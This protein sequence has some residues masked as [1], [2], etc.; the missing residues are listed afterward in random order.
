MNA[1]EQTLQLIKNAGE[2]GTTTNEIVAITG[3]TQNRVSAS[4]S[5]LF[6]KGA[7]RRESEG[8]AYRYRF[9]CELADIARRR[10]KAERRPPRGHVLVPDVLITVAVGSNQ[11]LN[12][13]VDEARGLYQ[14][15]HAFFG[16]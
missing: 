15:L 9:A 4:L 11:T 5:A 8:R 3:L 13:T 16:K 1:L 12:C 6:N 10:Q 7:V 2:R 14:Q